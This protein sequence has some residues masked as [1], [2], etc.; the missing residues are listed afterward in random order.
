MN[1]F[2]LEISRKS[3]GI[4]LNTLMQRLEAAYRTGSGVT[5]TPETA[6]EAPTVFAA[7]NGISKRMAAMPI[8][9][10][11]K[12]VK[13]GRE[14]KEEQP[15]HPVARLLK[16]PN[17]WQD[18]ATY[19]LDATSQ[20]LRY[21]NYYAFKRRGQ[22][23]PVRFLQ[24]LLSARTKPVAG[25][26]F[27]VVYQHQTRVGEAQ[28]YP[29]DRVHHPRLASLDF[30]VGQSPITAIRETIALEI[31]A[32]R[33]GSAF[34]GNGALP[35][36]VFEYAD[37]NRGHKDDEGRKQFIDDIQSKHA[38]VGRFLAMLLPKGVK[39]GQGFDVQN[40]KAQFL[41][42][43]KYQRTVIAGAFGVPPH[44]VGDLDK[45]TFNNVEQQS[46]DFVNSAVLPVVRVFECSM[47]RDLLTDED[48]RGGII[49]RFNLDALLRGDFK[50]RQEGSKIQR[51]AGIIN[52]NDWR[53]REN[54]NPI[55][56]EDGG[57]EY[58]RQGP[59]G[60]S[61]DAPDAG[62]GS[63]DNPEPGDETNGT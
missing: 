50:N 23:G 42:T 6:L 51:E 45:G 56:V 59:S 37:G 29:T 31:A 53:E 49:I 54:M 2:G 5:V 40:D 27:D 39:L 10:M 26:N 34:F 25:D 19:W 41:E 55:S 63:D 14:V 60:Q 24:P 4:D 58:W 44:L 36:M 17:P 9:V 8:H 11:K 3:N 43:R 57:E 52:P 13:K 28:E 7:V 16:R 21:G 38:G 46:L 47:E 61:G 18:E 62:T 33:F 12:T 48:R 30:L 15:N 22:T 1:L 32:E 35:G 20:L